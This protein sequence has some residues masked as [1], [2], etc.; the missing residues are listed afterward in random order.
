MP[1]IQSIRYVLGL[2]TVGC[3]AV[4]TIECR[5]FDATT[6]QITLGFQILILV[7]RHAFD[8]VGTWQG[9]IRT[10]GWMIGMRMRRMMMVLSR[11]H[12]AVAAAA[13][14]ALRRRR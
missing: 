5:P 11:R 2:E 3:H 8:R 7:R 14:R 6:S 10:I 13:V 1:G 4:V 9:P 12:P